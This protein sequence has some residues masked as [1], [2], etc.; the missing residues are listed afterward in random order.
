MHC[1]YT[2]NRDAVWL[3]FRLTGR[4]PLQLLSL[5]ST[6]PAGGIAQLF[7]WHYFCSSHV[8]HRL[9]RIQRPLTKFGTTKR[10]TCCAAFHGTAILQGMLWLEYCSGQE[11]SQYWEKRDCPRYRQAPSFFVNQPTPGISKLWPAGSICPAASFCPVTN[12]VW[13]VLINSPFLRTSQET[14]E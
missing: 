5:I 4:L 14:S 9:L 11:K 6:G 8:Q 13:T 7:L 3:L 10:L 1:K 12:N 2:E